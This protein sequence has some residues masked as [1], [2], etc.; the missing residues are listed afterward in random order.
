MSKSRGNLVFV[1]DLLKEWDPR[2]VRLAILSH[3]YRESWEWDDDHM[4]RATERLERWMAA[5]SASASEPVLDRVRAALDDDLDTPNALAAVDAAA[6]AGQGVAP[7]AALLGVDLS[8]E[9]TS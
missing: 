3:H 5:R 6:S 4:P 9:L 1:S 2:A 8:T 7:A